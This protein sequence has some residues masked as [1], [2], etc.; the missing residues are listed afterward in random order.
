[1]SQRVM[2]AMAIACEPRLLIADEPTTAFDVTVQAQIL[3]LIKQLQRASGL[4][5]IL[6]TSALGRC[7]SSRCD[8]RCR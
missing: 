4:G 3:E 6:I 7:N 5:L 1:M 8:P 2:V